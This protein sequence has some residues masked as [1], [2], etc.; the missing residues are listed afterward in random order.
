[1]VGINKPEPFGTG[2]NVPYKLQKV[3]YFRENFQAF[4]KF[5]PKIV[6]NLVV[7]VGVVPLT[8]MFLGQ[9][10]Q[11]QKVIVNRKAREQ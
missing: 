5:T 4:F 2:I 8:W 11:D 10:Q 7:L 9:V 3:Q 6:L 1:M